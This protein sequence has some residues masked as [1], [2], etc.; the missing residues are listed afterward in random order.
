MIIHNFQNNSVFYL[1]PSMLF[2]LLSLT[3]NF[4]IPFSFF[5]IVYL[6]FYF[7]LWS[8]KNNAFLFYMVDKS[9]IS[10]VKP[11]INLSVCFWGLGRHKNGQILTFGTLFKPLIGLVRGAFLSLGDKHSLL[12]F[13]FHWAA[14]SWRGREHTTHTP[15]TKTAFLVQTCIWI[16]DAP[17]QHTHTHRF[18]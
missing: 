12:S 17:G 11:L 3:Y 10:V 18:V 4:A 7:C 6:P 8:W 14:T 16:I 9:T 2:C 15:L 13:P 5:C 1:I